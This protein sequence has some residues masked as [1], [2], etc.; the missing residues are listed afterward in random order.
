MS[1]TSMTPLVTRP[2]LVPDNFEAPRRAS[3]DS[4]PRNTVPAGPTEQD[5]AAA[6]EEGRREARESEAAE[7]AR[8]GAAALQLVAATL[9]REAAEM[10][11]I[12]ERSAEAIAGVVLQALIAAFPAMEERLGAREAARFAAAILPG[13]AREPAVVIVIGPDGHDAVTQAWAKAA[14]VSV[15]LDPD[16]GPGDVRL[17]WRNG[18]AER[19]ASEIR[20][21]ILDEFKTIIADPESA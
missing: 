17:E 7:T 18:S 20:A 14:H 6:R 4:P 10:T 19:D 5:V 8:R 12:A 21:A 1:A 11:L 16:L 2:W 15:R 9:V 3:D 13:L